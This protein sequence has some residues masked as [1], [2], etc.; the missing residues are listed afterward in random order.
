MSDVRR[1]SN[2]ISRTVSGPMW[3]G[4]SLAELLDGVSAEEAAAHPIHGAHSIWE[5]VLHM[6]AWAEIGRARLNDQRTGDPKP[7]EDWPK[8]AGKS[9]AEWQNAKNQLFTEYHMLAEDAAN[10]GLERL[11]RIIPGKDHSA[12][13]MLHGLIEHGA[14]HGGQI[15]ILKRALASKK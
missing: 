2:F 8:P 9:K 15:A 5:I 10:L 14:Y 6:A 4:Q 3:H 7:A 1:L 11:R 12:Q 13:E